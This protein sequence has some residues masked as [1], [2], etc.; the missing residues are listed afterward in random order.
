VTHIL[1]A[2]SGINL[3]WTPNIP[4]LAFLAWPL[5]AYRGPVA[6]FNLLT[7]AAPSLGA[8]AGFLLCQTLTDKYFP[9][10]VGGWLFGF[11]SYEIG[12]LRGALPLDFIAFIPA[13]AWLAVLRH[14]DKL[15]G[16]SF[17][18]L[19]TALLTLQFGTS[20][21]ILATATLFGCVALAL[22]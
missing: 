15:S 22:T 4:A 10:L 9:S 1:W 17:V 13:L 11:S 21:E 6:S 5:T 7:T 19:V 2:L 8:F 14:K 20:L 16:G 18:A 3:T 12:Q